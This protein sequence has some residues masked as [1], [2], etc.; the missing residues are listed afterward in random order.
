[1]NERWLANGAVMTQLLFASVHD[2]LVERLGETK[3]LGAT[4][5]IIATLHTGSQT[6]RLPPHLQCLVTGGG[7][8]ENGQGVAVRHGFLLPMGVVMA[9]FRGQLRAAI[10]RGLAPGTLQVP[11]GQRHQQVENL[12]NKLG[13]Q[14]W[15]VPIRARYPSGQGVLIDLAR[16]RRGGPLSN[17]RWRACDGQQVVLAYE[18]RAKGPESPARQ[19]PRGLPREQCIGRWRLQVPPAGAVRVRCGGL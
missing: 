15:H 3:Y 6:L 17:R 1:L 5:G 18:E 8:P 10:C 4:P 2:T 11:A 19:R 16:D 14:K 7:R 9:G 12:L 13:R